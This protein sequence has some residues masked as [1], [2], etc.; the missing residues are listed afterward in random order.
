M[1]DHGDAKSLSRVPSLTSE[2]SS[3]TSHSDALTELAQHIRLKYVLDSEPDTVSTESGWD[4]SSA[5]YPCVFQI[6]DCEKQLHDIVSYKI[7]VF[8]HFGGHALPQHI[9]CFICDKQYHQHD[10]HDNAHA[11]N[12]VLDHIVEQHFD[13]SQLV[14]FIRPHLSLMRWMYSRRLIDDHQLKRAQMCP[15]PTV[16]HSVATAES[17]EAH[18][19]EAPIAPQTYTQETSDP[20]PPAWTTGY[21]DQPYV[22]VAGRRAERR[23]RDRPRLAA[24]RFAQAT[25]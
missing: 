6:L 2:I 9:S 16:L 24:S 15:V 21:H 22:V 12:L 4:D 7:H 14:N 17:A 11:W 5:R 25:M 13:G 8:S 20:L 18:L 1:A 3:R 19:P 10:G 23:D